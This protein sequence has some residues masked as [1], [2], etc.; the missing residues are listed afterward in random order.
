MTRSRRRTLALTASAAVHA[1]AFAVLTPVVAFHA[2]TRLATPD[3]PAMQVEI[4]RLP[5]GL[6]RITPPA[7]EPAAALTP[8]APGSPQ[9]S[10]PPEE[11]SP[12]PD[13]P[14]QVGVV[15]QD[16]LVDIDPLFRAPFVSAAGQAEAAL[17]AGLGCAHVDLQQLPRNL[18]DRC[19]AADEQ[20]A[21][22]GRPAPQSPPAEGHAPGVSA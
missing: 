12:L 16:S 18:A 8:S 22:R 21:R 19:A 5:D 7:P 2:R 13:N 15:A 4:I 10:P 14:A 6:G 9:S 17:R 1:L 11:A 3:A 20:I